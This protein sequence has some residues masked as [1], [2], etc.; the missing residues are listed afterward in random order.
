MMDKADRA[1]MPIRKGNLH[2]PEPEPEDVSPEESSRI[3]HELALTAWAFM[4]GKELD[5]AA[6]P[7]LQRRTIRV[8]RRP[9]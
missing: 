7:A 1:K 9:G 8:V 6:D 2:D 4:R 5:D 3:M